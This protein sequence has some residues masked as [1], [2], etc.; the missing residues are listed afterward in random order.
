LN[1]VVRLSSGIVYPDEE[2]GLLLY[3]YDQIASQPLAVLTGLSIPRCQDKP[4]VTP[5]AGADRRIPKLLGFC[6]FLGPLN[7]R[8]KRGPIP[9]SV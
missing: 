8:D 3:V 2:S 7:H 4:V 5:N 9:P 1:I 6:G